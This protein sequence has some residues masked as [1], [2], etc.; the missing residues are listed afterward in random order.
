MSVAV[1]LCGLQ[2]VILGYFYPAAVEPQRTAGLSIIPLDKQLA[3]VDIDITG[4][5]KIADDREFLPVEVQLAI[6]G[7]AG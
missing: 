7:K 3:A 5:N 2:T 6:L 4:L 1:N